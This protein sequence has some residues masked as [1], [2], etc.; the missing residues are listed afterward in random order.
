MDNNEKPRRDELL[1]EYLDV[2]EN[3]RHWAN[4]IFVRMTLFTF[5]TASLVSF[6]FQPAEELD[7][8]MKV[9]MKAVGLGIGIAFLIM[10]RRGL[11]YWEGLQ[12]RAKFLEEI[13]GFTQHTSS[14][15]NELFSTRKATKALLILVI[16]FWTLTLI[17]HSRI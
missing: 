2:S 15:Q 5:L 17:F 13:F 6:I 10:E 3:L 1:K 9:I 11:K 14:P 16:V 7:N 8:W 4:M 12:K